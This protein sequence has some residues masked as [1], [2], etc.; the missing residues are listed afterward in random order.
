MMDE[1]I[2]ELDRVIDEFI[3]LIE[4]NRLDLQLGADLC[5]I[6]W[7]RLHK[8]ERKLKNEQK[9]ANQKIK[10]RAENAERLRSAY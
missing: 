9:R 2:K 5:E 6:Y 1:A 3:G 4:Y 7:K 8:S 10:K